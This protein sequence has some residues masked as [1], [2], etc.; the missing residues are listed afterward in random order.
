MSRSMK[1]GIVLSTVAL[2]GAALIAAPA[3]ARAACPKYKPQ[4]PI[5]DSE[6]RAEATTA[7]VMQVTEKYTESKPLVIDYE[8]GPAF[9]FIQDPRDAEGQWGPIEDTKWFNIQLNTKARD[10]GVYIRQQWEPNSP[11]DMDL[12]LY[13]KSGAQIGSSGEFNLT[14]DIAPNTLGSGDGGPGYEQVLG[15]LGSRCMGITIESRAFT[16]PGRPMQLI[17]WLGQIR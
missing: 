14:G 13:D 11:D 16:S 8:H 5:T 1:F 4:E 17:I 3:G 15:L 9:W 12:Y 7:K 6:N 10:I 2:V